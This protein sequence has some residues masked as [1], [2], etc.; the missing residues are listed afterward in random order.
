MER[1]RPESPLQTAERRLREV[2]KHIAELSDIVARTR[3]IGHD[4]RP[5]ERVLDMFRHSRELALQRL[6]IERRIAANWRG[7][8]VTPFRRSPGRRS[9][10]R[11]DT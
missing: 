10:D 7:L 9:D 5:L 11:G 8:A 2:E 4:A 6:A 3:A 1:Y